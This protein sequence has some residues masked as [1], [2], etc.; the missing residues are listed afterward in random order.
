M[1]TEGELAMYSVLG[2]GIFNSI[3]FSN[4]YTLGIAGLGKYTSQ[5]SS[6]L[7]MAILGGALVPLIQGLLA[8]SSVGVQ[9]SFIVPVFC[10]LYIVY[11]GV[12]CARKLKNVEF[13]SN[14]SG[15]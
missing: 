5:G 4:I 11:F 6:L 10:Y 13:V 12:Y 8:D 15:H 3:M 7:V 14:S 2:I 9:K 1:F